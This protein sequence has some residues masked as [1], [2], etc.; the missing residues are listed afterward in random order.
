MALDPSNSS[1]VEQLALKGLTPTT[2]PPKA[3]HSRQLHERYHVSQ[4]LGILLS[5]AGGSG[6][7]PAGSVRPA[8]AQHWPVWDASTA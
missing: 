6:L 7:C 5:L 1:N 3:S 4:S 8:S 2:L